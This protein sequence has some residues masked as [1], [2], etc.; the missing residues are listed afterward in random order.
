MPTKVQLTPVNS[1]VGSKLTT[2]SVSKRETVGELF[3]AYGSAR[4]RQ[5]LL[6]GSENV[7]ELVFL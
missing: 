1:L 5:G 6:I 2:E 4:S 7:L 3:V